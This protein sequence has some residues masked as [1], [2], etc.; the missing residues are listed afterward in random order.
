MALKVGMQSAVSKAQELVLVEHAFEYSS[1][2]GRIISIKPNE[3]YILLKRTNEH[4]WQVCLDK[5][6]TPFYIPAKYVKVL[7]SAEKRFNGFQPLKDSL[8]DVQVPVASNEYSYKFLPPIPQVSANFTMPPSEIQPT[9][10]GSAITS[11]NVESASKALSP[12]MMPC[13]G[14]SNT[15]PKVSMPKLAATNTLQSSTVPRVTSNNVQPKVTLPQIHVNDLLTNAPQIHLSNTLPPINAQQF[16]STLPRSSTQS[17]PSDLPL[18][19]GASGLDSTHTYPQE[20]PEDNRTHAPMRTFHNSKKVVDPTKRI[21]FLCLNDAQPNILITHPSVKLKPEPSTAHHHQHLH[22]INDSSGPCRP[23]EVVTGPSNLTGS[24]EVLPSAQPIKEEEDF[25]P[26]YENLKPFKKESPRKRASSLQLSSTSTLDDWE[27]HTDTGSGQQFYYNSLTGVTTWDSPFDQPEDQG[28]S[29]TSLNSLSPL[30]EDSLWEKHFDE[31]T[32]QFYFFNPVTGETSWDPPEEGMS[33]QELTPMAPPYLS[34]D[35]R[36]PTP[37]A[38]Y[39]DYSP[40]EVERYPHADYSHDPQG[41]YEQ[42]PL[43]KSPV[44]ANSGWFCQVNKEG[45]KCYSNNSNSDIW[46]QSEDQSG[47]TYFYTPDGSFSQ[48]S[49]PRVGTP[50]LHTPNDD[51]NVFTKLQLNYPAFSPR[52][53][54]EDFGQQLRRAGSEDNLDIVG[55]HHHHHQTK[56]LEKAGVL[57]KA[58][59]SD[60]GKKLRKS[61]SSSWTVLEGGILT[62]FKDGKNLSSNSA[63]QSQLSTPEYTVR[64]EGATLGWATKDKSSKKHVL[65]LKT[66]DG[67]EF[68]IHHDSETITADWHES[69]KNSI[70]RNIRLFADHTP[71]DELEPFQ[72]FGSTEKLGTKDEKKNSSMGSGS[73]SDSDRKVRAKLKKFLQRRPTL[74]SLRDKG[75]IKEQVFG[76]PLQQLCDREKHNVPEFVRKAIQAV[77]R[78]GLDIDGLYRVSGNL[79]TIQKLRHKVDQEENINLEDGRWEDVHVL[80]GALKLFFRELPEPLFPFSHFDMFIET[81]KLNDPVL[82]KKQLK[83]LIQSLPPPNQET[84]QFL[85]RHLCNV[86][87]YRESNRMSIQSVAIVFGPTLLRPSMEGA[88]IAMYMVFQNQIVEQV[89]TQYKYIFNTS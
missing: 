10:S 54:T 62:F 75:Y 24:N 28:H 68:L 64:L 17:L 69:I 78:R 59:I 37:E 35:R 70:A 16:S 19:C 1:K 60:S 76:C 12:V 6:T 71:E 77:E 5:T 47:K 32:R 27:T 89:L 85:F 26:L 50:R 8:E 22:K 38:D 88:N 4:W 42:I 25:G 44:D 46:V 83:E 33:F 72:E 79:A 36:P 81:I 31:A 87:E 66:R 58:K 67:S 14:T 51:N 65:E 15:L 74:Q 57:H 41:L 7:P 2:D 63:R 30:A 45:K 11:R 61:W 3:R 55:N 21:S 73:N 29:P 86:I 40:E 80:T 18:V 53:D 23:E 82:K 52:K 48:W 9:I 20:Q 56:S 39:P 49:L 13:I 34:V 84:M 43:D